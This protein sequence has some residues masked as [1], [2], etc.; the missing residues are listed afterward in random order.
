MKAALTA[1]RL[2]EVLHYD[3]ETGVFTRAVKRAWN[4]LGSE[5]VLPTHGYLK[6]GVDGVQYFAHRLAWLHVHGS[7]PRE[8]IDH[9]NGCKTDNRIANLREASS[10]T[11]CEN[12]HEARSDNVSSGILG[13]HWSEYHQKWKA[14]IRV[15]GRLKHLKYCNSIDEARDV[16]LNAKRKLHE[17]CTI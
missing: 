4:A 17:G 9:M 2:R 10:R 7:W 12:R 15:N 8:F 11:N 13:V 16:Y 5:N 3:P 14:Q 1:E 6:L